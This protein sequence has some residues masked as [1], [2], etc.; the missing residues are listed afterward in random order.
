[1]KFKIKLK[2]RK[3]RIINQFDVILLHVFAKA[4]IFVHYKLTNIFMAIGVGQTAPDFTLFSDKKKA[5]K[6]AIFVI[7]T[8]YFDQKVY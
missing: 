4:R 5:V 6:R 2:R 3:N 1:M 8:E 7:D